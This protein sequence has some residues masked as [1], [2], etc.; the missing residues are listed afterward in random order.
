MDTA[1]ARR[2]RRSSKPLEDPAQ[3]ISLDVHSQR[4]GSLGGSDPCLSS[5]DLGPALTR[6]TLAEARFESFG[7]SCD[8]TV[9]PAPTTRDG[10]A[11][12]GAPP[13]TR[14]AQSARQV[15]R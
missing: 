14:S 9:E 13:G 7:C 2:I 11:Q 6:A 3:A 10:A 1:Y 15:E 12:I 4:K 8:R 5:V